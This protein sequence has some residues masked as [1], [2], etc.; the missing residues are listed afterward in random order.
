MV[1]QRGKEVVLLHVLIKMIW[2]L[3]VASWSNVFLSYVAVDTHFDNVVK[4]VTD[5]SGMAIGESSNTLVWSS[6]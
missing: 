4:D 1:V 2:V 5:P 3:E 6:D